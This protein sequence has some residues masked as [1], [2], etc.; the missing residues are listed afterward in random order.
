MAMVSEAPDVFIG[1]GRV[2]MWSSISLYGHAAKAQVSRFGILL[3]TH[4]FLSSWRQPLIERYNQV[5][6]GATLNCSPNPF[7]AFVAEVL[8][9]RRTGT[10]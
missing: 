10:Y 6:P 5:G 2:V 3:F 1:E 9:A 8:R 7:A 4:L